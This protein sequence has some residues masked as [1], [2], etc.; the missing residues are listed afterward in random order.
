MR[1]HCQVR[2][3]SN[4]YVKSVIGPFNSISISSEFLDNF[5]CLL[6]R[7]SISGHKTIMS[8]VVG[9][10][11]L[12]SGKALFRRQRHI[13]G[14]RQLLIVPGNRTIGATPHKVRLMAVDD[15]KCH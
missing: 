3:A 10:A 15:L 12:S 11:V 5:C 4:K 13:F 6:A 8:M 2:W 1:D 7:V 14:L 9:I